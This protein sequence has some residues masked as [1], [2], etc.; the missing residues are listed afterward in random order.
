MKKIFSLTIL[1]LLISALFIG[2]VGTPEKPNNNDGSSGDQSPENGG[3]STENE[4]QSPENGSESTE[5][6][7]QS[8]ES[9]GENTENEGQ[10]PENGDENTDNESQSPE[11]GGENTENEGQ[12]PENGDENTENESQSPENGGENT[13]NEENTEDSTPAPVVGNKV[14]NII[15]SITLERVDGG[16]VSPDD[17][18]GKIVI[19]NI[20]A[21]WCPP[22]KAE[23]PDFDKIA[24]EYADDVVIIAAHDYYLKHN[25]P[26]YINENFADSKIIFAY[27][28]SSGTAFYAAGGGEYI[29]RTAIINKDGVIIYSNYGI[30]TH[31]QLVKI[32]ESNK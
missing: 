26:A 14:G 9:G 2:C 1:V 12:F 6:E 8:P 25:A 19:L 28:T 31:S 13:E 20:W 10:S 4:G 22:C 29:P 17:Y 18:R 23:L 24:T 21:T 11:N 7:G 16:T 3:E 5:N 32:I 27:D 15:K 30:L